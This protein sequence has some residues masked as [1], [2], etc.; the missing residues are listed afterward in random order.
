MLP[1]PNLHMQLAHLEGI[2]TVRSFHMPGHS[3]NNDITPVL[4]RAVD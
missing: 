1:T 3:K 2:E 4:A